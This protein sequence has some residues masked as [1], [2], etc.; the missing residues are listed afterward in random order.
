V[1]KLFATLTLS[2]LIAAA[3]IVSAQQ[4]SKPKPAAPAGQH[5]MVTPDQIKWG[6]GPP[7]LPPGAQAAVIA[8]DPSK[9]AMFVIRAKF[10]D[11]YT[12]PPHWHPTDEYVTVLSG[13][14]MA[15]LGDKLDPA[16]MHALPA[17]GMAK[18]PRKTNHYVRAKGETIIQVQAVGPFE[19]TYVNPNDDPR[20][21]KTTTSTRDSGKPVVASR[22]S[23]LERHAD[24]IAQRVARIGARIESRLERVANRLSRIPDRL[25]RIPTRIE[26]AIDRLL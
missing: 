9:P 21:K 13:T 11:G 12:V 24:R 14:L 20:R 26:R 6:P 1:R 15:G 10:P 8:G 3:A 19:V 16:S 2:A 4:T 5:V 25:S 7:A 23:R 18:M 22:L 17:G